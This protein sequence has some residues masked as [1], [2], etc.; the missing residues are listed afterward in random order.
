MAVSSRTRTTITTRIDSPVPRRHKRKKELS[1]GAVV[2]IVLA[3]FIIFKI[4]NQN[5]GPVRL[6]PAAQRGR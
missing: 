2:L 1:V 6:Q 3:V 5:H 4:V